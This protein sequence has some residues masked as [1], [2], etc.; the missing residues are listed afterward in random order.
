MSALANDLTSIGMAPA[1]WRPHGRRHQSHYR[2]RHR[3]RL[4]P[5]VY[6]G[7]VCL[8][9]TQHQATAC[10]IDSAFPVGETA[11]V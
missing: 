3:R 1:P 11:E 6:G 5:P 4:Q 10:T 8:L 9:T 2:R 7:N